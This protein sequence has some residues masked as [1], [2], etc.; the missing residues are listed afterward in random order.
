MNWPIKIVSGG[1]S[2]V[3][4][5]ALDTA[6]AHGIPCG[7]W[8]PKGRL[9]EDGAIA[10]HYPLRETPTTVY[11]ERTAW[12]VRD[13]DGTLVLAWGEPSDGTALTV[14]LAL[15][16]GKPCLVADLA[17]PWRLDKTADWVE[18]NGIRVLNVAGPRSSKAPTAYEETRNYLN[19]LLD[20]LG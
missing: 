6:L 13:S 7:G 17:G 16:M 18:T 12:N 15:R 19:S 14:E 5:A 11:A 3:D 4:R 8:C 9:A 10:P 1:Q 2:G 20:Q